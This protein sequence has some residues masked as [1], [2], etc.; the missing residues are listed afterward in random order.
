[1][2]HQH[3]VRAYPPNLSL[4]YEVNASNETPARLHENSNCPAVLTKGFAIND[5]ADEGALIASSKYSYSKFSQVRSSWLCNSSLL[6]SAL[7]WVAQFRLF[8]DTPPSSPFRQLSSSFMVSRTIHQRRAVIL[9][10][11]LSRGSLVTCL[12]VSWC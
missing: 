10:A 1:M 11:L 7:C 9:V 3:L 6:T 2:L 5:D 8:R 12:P 4:S